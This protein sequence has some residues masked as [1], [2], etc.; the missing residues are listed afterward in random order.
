MACGDGTE[1]KRVD[2][3]EDN[4]VDAD[5]NAQRDGDGDG[6]SRAAPHRSQRVAHVAHEVAEQAGAAT[7]AHRFAMLID[8]AEGNKGPAPCLVR[9]KT[10]RDEPFRLHR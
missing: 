2:E 4:A 3:P 5:A 6:K 10:E 9:W 7:V 8:P 1:Q